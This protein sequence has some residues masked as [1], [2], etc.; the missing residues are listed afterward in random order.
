MNLE[1]VRAID[2]RCSELHTRIGDLQSSFPLRG[3]DSIAEIRELLGAPP[4]GPGHQPR[5]TN[6]RHVPEH[7]CR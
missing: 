4:P 5:R 3:A 1:L 2:R 6:R 7:V